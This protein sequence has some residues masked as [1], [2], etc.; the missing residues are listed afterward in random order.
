M[1]P[2]A[3]F[4]KSADIHDLSWVDDFPARKFDVEAF[5][6]KSFKQI[7][8]ELSCRFM[9]EDQICKALMLPKVDLDK[10]CIAV[11]GMSCHEACEFYRTN[12]DS[13][14]RD[15]LWQLAMTGNS[16][17]TKIYSEYIAGLGQRNQTDV[18][19]I[20]VTVNVSKEDDD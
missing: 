9:N 5:E 20:K 14:V 3:T 18:N 8:K 7:F 10:R 4:K 19:G 12:A 11:Y 1:K 2:D 17:A 16:A 6:G 15:V 13:E